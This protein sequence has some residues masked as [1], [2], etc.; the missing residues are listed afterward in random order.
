MRGVLCVVIN[1]NIIVGIMTGVK[2]GNAKSMDEQ[3][4]R[5]LS[6]TN[7]QLKPNISLEETQKWVSS[8]FD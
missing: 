1:V 8:F 3:Y 7:K 5:A 2:N 6:K 4:T